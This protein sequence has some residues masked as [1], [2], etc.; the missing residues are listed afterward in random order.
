VS[1]TAPLAEFNALISMENIQPF[2]FSKKFSPLLPGRL[3]AILF[4]QQGLLVMFGLLWLA[5]LIAALT[6]AWN[7]NKVWWLVIG[8][9]ILLFPH[10]FITWHGDVMGIYRHVMSASIQFYLG[11]WLLV[12]FALDSVLSLKTLQPGL[13]KIPSLK[14]VEQ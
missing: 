13:V 12:L 11:M 4:P 7:Q 5:I 10:Y 14:K 1:I 9:N 2:L 6:R 8:L 3:E